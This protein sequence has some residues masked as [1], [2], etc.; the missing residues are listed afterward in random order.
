MFP[1]LAE[2]FRE[3]FDIVQLPAVGYPGWLKF[4]FLLLS[5]H[6]VKKSWY[7]R[8]RHWIEHSPF[9]FNL[10]TRRYGRRLA[11]VDGEFDMILHFGAMC[12]PAPIVDKPY[13]VFTDSCRALS[14]SNPHDEVCHFVS[15][16]EERQWLALEGGV[17]RGARR[18]FVG[19]EFVKRALTSRYG[20]SPTRVVVTGFGAG[21]GFGDVSEKSF[22]G[23]TILYVGKGDFEKKGGLVLLDAF[24]RVRRQRPDAQ[25]HIVGQPSLAARP[26]VVSHGYVSDRAKLLTLLR[27]AHVLTLPSLVDR[28]GIVL[29]EAMACSTPCVAS[30]YGAMPEVVADAGLI[31]P[32]G[33][34][35]AL[36]AA[37]LSLLGDPQRSRQLGANGRRR[38]EARYNWPT[39]WA[40]VRSEIAQAMAEG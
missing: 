37:L 22:D 29:V 31:V 14:A 16:R 27:Q 32:Q 39:I 33:D 4:L 9:S 13:F 25:L 6:P 3:E 36:A 1:P 15:R 7:R 20:V 10:M 2:R 21:K 28:F 12:A 11:A 24:E 30:D 34:A 17:Y 26:G 5:F 35:G 23:R 19:S 18:I 38:Y 40:T 8:W